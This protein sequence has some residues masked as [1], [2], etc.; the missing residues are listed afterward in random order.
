MGRVKL[1]IKRLEN[2][3]GRQATYAKRKHGIMKK[4]NELSILCDIDIVL[5]MF[6]PSGKPSICRGTR[7]SIEDVIAKFAQLTPQERAKRKLESLEDLTNQARSLDTQLAE[8]NKRL[9]YWTTPDKINSL[10]HLGQ[11]EDSIRDSLNQIR[12]HKENLQKQQLMSLECS[13]QFQNGMHI[14]FRMGA[15]QQIQPLSWIPNNDNRHIIFPED[16]NLIPHRDVECSATSSLGSYSGYFGTGKNSEIPSSGQENGMLNQ[17]PRTAPLRLQLGGQYPYLPYNVNLLNE[18][19]FQPAAQMNPQEDPLDYHVNGNFGTSRP[20]YETTQHGWA[21]TSGHCAVNMFDEHLYSQLRVPLG[22]ALSNRI[23]VKLGLLIQ[24][25][26]YNYI[27]SHP[28]VQF[29]Q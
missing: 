1:K 9:S 7:S 27:S 13:S 28:A 23:L 15:E 25:S 29:L 14:P 4:A 11:M 8:I 22:S 24:G 5:L 17:L 16:P 12:T 20:G 26:C 18:T 19:K 10:E 6:S 3:N 21:S 2:T